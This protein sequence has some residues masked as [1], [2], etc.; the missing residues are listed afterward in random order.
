M[1]VRKSRQASS[2][3]AFRDVSDFE[4]NLYLAQRSAEIGV[5]RGKMKQQ[6]G[7][8]TERNADIVRADIFIDT[9]LI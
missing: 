4:M 7:A 2:D 1:I 5:S 3:I 9:S 6:R 8:N